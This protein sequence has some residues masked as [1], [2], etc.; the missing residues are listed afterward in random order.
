MKFA[1]IHNIKWRLEPAWFCQFTYTS[2][3][4]PMHAGW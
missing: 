4:G 2:F 3:N 1:A